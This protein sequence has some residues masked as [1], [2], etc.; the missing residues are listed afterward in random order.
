MKAGQKGKTWSHRDTPHLKSCWTG[1]ELRSASDQLVIAQL[2][3]VV[4]G[5]IRRPISVH[6]SFWPSR[7]QVFLSLPG[8]RSLV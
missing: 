1:T 7:N 5:M 2:I 6:A 3:C 8:C 4:S